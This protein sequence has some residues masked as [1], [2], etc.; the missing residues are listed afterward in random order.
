M[1]LSK[2]IVRSRELLDFIEN[3][4]SVFHVVENLS[5]IYDEAGF[6]RLDERDEWNLS[7]GQA[8]YVTRN[9]SSILAFSIPEDINGAKLMVAAT[10]SDSPTFRIK[11]NPSMNIEKYVKLNV[12]KYGGM[13][14]SSWM[15][16]PLSIAGRVVVECSGEEDVEISEHTRK[17]GRNARLET[18]LVN[19]DEDLCMIPNVAIHMN[20][21][22]NDGS[23]YNA[24]TDM[25]P[26]I[27]LT[28]GE[29]GFEDLLSEYADVMPE[30]ILAYDLFLYVRERGRILGANH[31]FI[32]SP[33]LDD[34]QCAYFSSLAM[35]E[36]R[37][38]QN[39]NICVAFDNEEVGSGTKQGADSTF[40]EDVIVRIGESLA[41]SKERMQQLIAEGFLISADNAHAVHPNH[42]E[43]ADPTNRPYINGG[44]VI[45]SH[46]GQK[47]TTDA[48]SAAKLKL[49]CK[50]GQIPVQTFANRSDQ[51]GGST[52]GNISTA[53]VSI[54]SV[55]IGMPMLAMHSAMETAGTFD[56]EYVARLFES[57]FRNGVSEIV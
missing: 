7:C 10:H 14:M 44:V 31:E 47:Y 12:E 32:M 25:A 40:L 29:R 56:N 55:D 17:I 35:A 20:R 28:D 48:V 34:L 15:D 23:A 26:L 16:R 8:Y 49:L 53:H 24:Q 2:E 18:K 50:D 54:S 11:M 38:D 33:K 22:M 6:V 36:V 9:D 41:F 43:K 45:K 46:G 13:I 51:A 37:S 21:N 42:P 3:S 19:I 4:P 52:L 39:I 30:Q 1:E 5:K 57:F 27:G